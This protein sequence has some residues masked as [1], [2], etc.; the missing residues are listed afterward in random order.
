MNDV[1]SILCPTRKRTHMLQNMISSCTATCEFP[2][3]LEFV[4]YVDNDDDETYEFL[5]KLPSPQVSVVRGERIMF[6]DMWNK[7]YEKASGDI[8]FTGNDDFLFKTP[9]W[10]TVVR[11]K[12]LEYPDRIVDIFVYDGVHKKGAFGAIHF[13][14]RKWAEVVGYV[15]PPYFVCDWSD[16]W[17]S[18]VSQMIRRQVFLDIY[19]EHVHPCV[20]KCEWDETHVE[21][22]KMGRDQNVAELYNS[23]FL[24]RVTDANK[25]SDYIY[26]CQ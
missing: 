18:E 4:F 15:F 26:K 12:F 6:T 19:I 25:L 10:D 23:L 20:N 3:L 8:L 16:N 11:S 22:K 5:Q 13:V 24:E 1:I 9:N 7:C 14:H 2:E 21:R 17:L